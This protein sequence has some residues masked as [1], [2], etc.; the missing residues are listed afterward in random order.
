MAYTKHVDPDVKPLTLT[1][2]VYKDLPIQLDVY[3]P[4]FA[5]HVSD[6]SNTN[7]T[8]VPAVVYFHGGGLTVGNRQSWFPRWMQ[9][10]PCSSQLFVLTFNLPR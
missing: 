8:P 6:V 4:L 9:S 7:Q 5:Q 3:P 1:Y 10:Q 2:K